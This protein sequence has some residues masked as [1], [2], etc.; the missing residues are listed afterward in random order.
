MSSSCELHEA[1]DQESSVVERLRRA[2]DEEVRRREDAERNVGR[3]FFS[4]RN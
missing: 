3:D 2:L 4:Q 1:L